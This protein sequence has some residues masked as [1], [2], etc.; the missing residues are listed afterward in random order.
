MSRTIGVR[1]SRNESLNSILKAYFACVF[2]RC[3]ICDSTLSVIVWD[4]TMINDEGITVDMFEAGD[5]GM[6]TRPALKSICFTV[7][8]VGSPQHSEQFF[9]NH[10]EQLD[11][12]LVEWQEQLPIIMDIPTRE[13]ITS[14]IKT[15]ADGAQLP[16]SPFTGEQ[17]EPPES[18]RYC[19]HAANKIT[20]IIS[21]LLEKAPWIL[22]QD[23]AAGYAL[24]M[25]IRVYYHNTMDWG[26]M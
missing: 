23:I 1:T 13:S 12:E 3:F 22:K 24:N 5:L 15:M 18:Q 2:W 26:K 20:R 25:V 21:V 10:L 19:T 16:Y 7:N 6:R 4:P 14:P 8:A 17:D 11:M 9:L